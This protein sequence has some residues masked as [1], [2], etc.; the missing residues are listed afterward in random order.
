MS[1]TFDTRELEAIFRELVEN[2]KNIP[3]VLVAAPFVTAVDD[4]INSEG[5]GRWP[6]FSEVTFRFHPHRRGGKLLRDTNVLSNIQ[7][8]N[9]QSIGKAK[10]FSPA[11][12]AYKHANGYRKGKERIPKRDFLDINMEAT[13]EKACI[14]VV[15]EIVRS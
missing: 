8:D 6:P 5:Q 4:E 2:A 10:I 14:A 1:V 13:T 12:Y 9:Q 11:K 7:V 15:Q 3:M